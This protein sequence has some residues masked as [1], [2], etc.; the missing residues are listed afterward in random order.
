MEQDNLTL[1]LLDLIERPAFCMKDSI[2]AYANRSAQQMQIIPGTKADDLFPP[3]DNA[4]Q[5]YAG[6]QLSL[7]VLASGVPCKAQLSRS[8]NYDVFVLDCETPELRA[9]A[10]A[11]QHLRNPLSTVMTVADRL[12]AEDPEQAMHFRHLQRGL[13]QLHRIV[14]NMSD[15][16]RYQHSS[17][18]RMETTD[19]SSVFNESMEAITA[20]LEQSGIRVTYSGLNQPVLGLADREMLER[21]IYNLVS[22]AVKFMSEGSTLDARLTQNANALCFTVQNPDQCQQWS[23]P[24]ARFLREPGAEDSRHGI[25]LGMELIRAVAAG[26][27]GTVLVDQPEDGSF[28]IAMTINIT[29]SAENT[30][31]DAV[32][33]PTSNYA[34]GRDRSLLELSEILPA[35]AYADKN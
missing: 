6:G 19:L 11:A 4:Y 2:V 14:C 20:Q 32:K 27:G 16:Y 8:G 33:L 23:N 34:G 26:H 10:L 15:A 5:Q 29:N 7:T 3:K 9:I 12:S 28:R 35:E 24:F 18:M 1:S 22:N 25:G 21:A 13:H 31:R 30:V 17:A